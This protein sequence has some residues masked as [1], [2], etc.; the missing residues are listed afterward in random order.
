MVNYITC[1]RNGQLITCN[2]N[3][4]LYHIPQEWLTASHTTG[5]V[6]YII[7]Y[8][9]GQLYYIPQEWS[10]IS[11]ATAAGMG[12]C[13]PTQKKKTEAQPCQSRG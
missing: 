8:R 12:N 11:Y 13:I 5:M 4:Q 3:G 2:R 9:N 10:T 7:C 6:N 1:N